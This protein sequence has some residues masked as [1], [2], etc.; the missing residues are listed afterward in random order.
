MAQ[1]A[2]LI[3]MRM[4]TRWEGRLYHE[5]TYTRG[6]EWKKE[7]SPQAVDSITVS[8]TLV[9]GGADNRELCRAPATKTAFSQF[10]GG[11][12]RGWGEVSEF[13]VVVVVVMGWG[14][15]PSAGAI[16]YDSGDIAHPNLPSS[17]TRVQG[18]KISKHPGKTILPASK[19]PSLFFRWI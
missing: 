5:Y 7:L 4:H 13:V 16:S 15:Q 3:R 6:R 18:R 12:S 17:Y 11:E 19:L 14:E 9:H 2:R 1:A 8:V 10:Q